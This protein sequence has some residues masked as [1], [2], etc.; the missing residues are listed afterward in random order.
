MTSARAAATPPADA[1][2]SLVA[3]DDAATKVLMALH[4]LAQQATLYDDNNEAQRQAI[5]NTAEA[6]RA[7]GAATGRNI[8][9]YFSERAIYVGRRLLRATRST[10]TAASQLRNLLSRL[11]ASQIS[12]G[13]DVPDDDLQKLQHAFSRATTDA[14]GAAPGDLARIRLRV[15]RP[16]GEIAELDKLE[17]DERAVKVYALAI[18][19]VRRFYEQLLDGKW[20]ISSHVRR[21]SEELITLGDTVSPAVL[22]TTVCRP[23]H[24][25][26]ERTVSAAL[27]ALCMAQQLTGDQR[28]LRWL[29]TGALL[30]DVG[31]PRVA[32]LDPDGS[33]RLGLRVPILGEGQYGELPGA[34][35]FVTTALG[36]LTDAGMMRSVVVYEAL[37]IEHQRD[38]GP[39][40]DGER[41]P[42]MLSR[43]LACARLFQH[44]LSTG[45]AA[46]DIVADLLQNAAGEVDR[47]IVQLLMATLN[48]LPTGTIVE[49]DDGHWARVV[50]PP[51]DRI[52][53]GRP[54][55]R[56]ISRPGHEV[57]SR[58]VD[59]NQPVGS[60]APPS[61]TRIVAAVDQQPVE[62]G[63]A[64]TTGI[65]RRTGL[66]ELPAI[67]ANMPVS[68]KAP[69]STR[70]ASAD[71]VRAPLIPRGAGSARGTLAKTPLVHL[72]VYAADNALTGTLLL[73]VG[74]DRSALYFRDGTPC[75]SQ[76]PANVV[77]PTFGH[78]DVAKQRLVDQVGYMMQLPEETAYAFYSKIDMLAIQSEALSV[79][80]DP[81]PLIMMGVRKHLDYDT[82]DTVLPR[83][84]NTPLSLHERATPARLGLKPGEREVILL[85]R[86]QPMSLNDMLADESVDEDLAQRTVYALLITR[87]LALGDDG[88]LPVG[89]SR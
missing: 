74:A 64:L 20:E 33:R 47:W 10:Y 54:L 37:H 36:R 7:Y 17:P 11:G 44:R 66:D 38:T 52:D 58:Y 77:T 53:F 18:V 30:C 23:A 50:S 68:D 83:I 79:A 71:E 14:S 61:I 12:I 60:E 76:V 15:G 27:L 4:R 16:P 29:A 34:T 19:I 41:G 1:A 59:L 57:E 86:K 2:A 88:R 32:G 48:V 42:A 69:D 70:G 85:L 62:P 6:A 13:H 45:N 73:T 78:D 75:K 22:A 5:H 9:I 35:A 56:L 84:A 87:Q 31:K 3:E 8:N 89:A 51:L 28:L 81:L 25:D 21:I 80:C 40:Y 24:D 49:L 46:A 43:L 67:A 65:R 39:I 26:A 72:L 63:G 82:F 55:V